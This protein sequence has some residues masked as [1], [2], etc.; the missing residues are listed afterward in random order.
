MAGTSVSRYGVFNVREKKSVNTQEAKREL[1]SSRVSLR[2]WVRIWA[3]ENS[4]TARMCEPVHILKA[5]I[6]GWLFAIIATDQ[7]YH[8]H[9]H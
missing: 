2:L 8:L 7:L 4:G 3:K 9:I 1:F 5:V 6:L